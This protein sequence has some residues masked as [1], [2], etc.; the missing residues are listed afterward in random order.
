VGREQPHL[1]RVALPWLVRVVAIRLMGLAAL[2]AA[3]VVLASAASEATTY[4]AAAYTYA[5]PAKGV[6]AALRNRRV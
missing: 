2:G 6:I 1:D 3:H 4:G 5:A